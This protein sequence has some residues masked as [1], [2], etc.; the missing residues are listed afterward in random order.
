MFNVMLLMSLTPLRQGVCH[1]QL[2]MSIMK[3][4]KDVI[5]EFHVKHQDK[6]LQL[7]FVNVHLIRRETKGYL[8]N[9]KNNAVVQLIYPYG[10][11]S[12]VLSVQLAQNMMKN[13]NNVI[14]VLKD[15]SETL[16]VMH[17]FQAS[18][19]FIIIYRCHSLSIL[20]HQSEYRKTTQLLLFQLLC[21]Y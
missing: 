14:T 9:S 21:S 10:M 18:D 13:N 1:V 16:L 5:A 17:V 11:E 6:S 12:I 20:L 19:Q 2:I 3:T 7:I 8:M 15:S 4:L